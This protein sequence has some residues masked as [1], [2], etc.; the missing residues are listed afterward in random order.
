MCAMYIGICIP[1]FC[2]SIFT[3]V[4]P[5][6]YPAAEVT[7]G[8]RRLHPEVP[9]QAR[10]FSLTQ[11]MLCSMAG[12]HTAQCPMG[13]LFE[14]SVETSRRSIHCPMPYAAS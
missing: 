12:T 10:P 9:A 8:W 13:M 7:T 6:T 2:V 3:C 4:I 14:H 11:P 5:V 1:T